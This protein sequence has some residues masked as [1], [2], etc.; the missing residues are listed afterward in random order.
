VSSTNL[1][2]NFDMKIQQKKL[3]GKLVKMEQP[4]A[5]VPISFELHAKI[6]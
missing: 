2:G 3:I 1:L 6:R 5:K 4:H